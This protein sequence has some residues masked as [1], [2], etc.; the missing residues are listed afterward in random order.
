MY[1]EKV[2]D[3]IA[4]APVGHHGHVDS[5]A[6]SIYSLTHLRV[7]LIFS[8]TSVIFTTMTQM[9]T[10]RMENRDDVI[11]SCHGNGFGGGSGGVDA[12]TDLQQRQ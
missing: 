10:P 4:N 5:L 3:A 6:I 1:L 8:M 7:S 12:E 2:I 9:P 11:V